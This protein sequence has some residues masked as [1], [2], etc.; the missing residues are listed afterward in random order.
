MYPVPFTLSQNA[1][2]KPSL[3]LDGSVTQSALKPPWNVTKRCKE[4]GEDLTW[5]VQKIDSYLN[6]KH[7]LN[8]EQIRLEPYRGYQHL[9]C[10]FHSVQSLLLNW[11]L[12][13]CIDKRDVYWSDH[14]SYFWAYQNI[15]NSFLRAKNTRG[16]WGI[17]VYAGDEPSKSKAVSSS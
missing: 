6:F 1:N 8:F 9:K 13:G 10:T 2:V 5:V 16:D 7:Y 3:H 14:A 15:V 4:T 17:Q 12:H 11:E